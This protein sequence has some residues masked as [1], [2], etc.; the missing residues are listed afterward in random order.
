MSTHAHYDA[1]LMPIVFMASLDGLR[2]LAGWPRVGRW[3]VRGYPWAAAAVMVSLS[4][5]AY[6]FPRL[7][8]SSFY[9]PESQ[10]ASTSRLMRHVPPGAAIRTDNNLAPLFISRNDVSM[11]Y[12]GVPDLPV[13]HW[14][15]TDVTGCSLNAPMLWKLAYLRALAPYT[16]HTW[17]DGRVVLIE[18]GDN[19]SAAPAGVPGTFRHC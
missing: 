18:L 11:L 17:R 14:L 13:D 19:S 6:P 15:I 12:D 4:V 8:H 7:L 5:A 16:V 3:L 9:S 10:V 1:V 2:S